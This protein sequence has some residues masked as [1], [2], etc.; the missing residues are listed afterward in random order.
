MTIVHNFVNSNSIGGIGESIF[1]T[2]LSKLGEVKVVTKDK[3]WQ[4]QGVDFILEDVKY[5]TKFDTKAFST[6]NIA[7]ETISR[8][9]D[10]KIIKEGWVHTSKADCI[11]YIFLE[12]DTWSIYFFT[13]TEI[14]ELA[15]IPTYKIKEIRNFGY[16]SEV[17]L[18]PIEDLSYKLKM[19]FPV[20]G[21]AS[22]DVLD[23]VHTYLK[24]G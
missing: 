4:V 18:V 10:N 19:Q 5:D 8:K 24:D 1:Y 23:K 12:N 2:L 9:K 13:N 6:G 22:I 21:E 15:A 14:K 11:A 17:V 16:E 7:L 3:K 20:V